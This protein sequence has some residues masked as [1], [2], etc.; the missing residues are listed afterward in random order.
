[1]TDE[2][3]NGL[4]T[5]LMELWQSGGTS[6]TGETFDMKRQIEGWAHAFDR[7]IF[8]RNVLEYG[9]S[10]IVLVRSGLEFASGERHWTVPLT[11]VVITLFIVSYIWQKNRRARPADPD[12]SAADYRAAL[13]ARIDS[14]I[15][16]AA[17]ARYW[18]VLPVWIFFVVVFAAGIVRTPDPARIAQFA[19]EF[20][21]GT[22]IAVLIVWLNERYGIRR[23]QRTRK[24]V[25]SL[26]TE[27]L[28]QW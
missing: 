25:Q 3:D 1:M 9:A 21:L 8:W 23:L 16:L 15:A 13:L 28:N 19:M 10:L 27:G 26:N 17:S 24:R 11:S 20:L 6:Q 2:Q 18:Y 14:Q 22:S 5:A 4:D 7:R 12:A